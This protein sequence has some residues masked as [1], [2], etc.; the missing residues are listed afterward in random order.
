MQYW[1]DVSFEF[2][3]KVSADSQSVASNAA[4]LTFQSV[5]SAIKTHLP[6]RVQQR[7]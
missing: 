2:E 7:P 6:A 3:R 1:F 4:S 5:V